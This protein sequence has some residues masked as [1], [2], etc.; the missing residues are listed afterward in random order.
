MKQSQ[1]FTKTRKEAPA[2]EVSK[3]AELL[4]RGGFINK[5]MAGV[6]SY[7]PLGL[8]VMNKISN[9]IREE[10]DAIGGQ[11]VKMTVL[12]DADVWQKS[13][14]WSDEVVDNWFKTKLKNDTEIGL[15]F[16]HEEPLTALLK[17]H[18]QSYKDLPVYPYQIQAKFR[19]ETR[20]KS[21]V[22]RG[23]E[24]LM[25]DMYSFSRNEAEH[26]A[27]YEKVQHAYKKIY[28]R[29]GVG[30]LTYMTFA[31][32]GTF[33][34]YSHEFQTITGAGEDLIYVDEETGIAVNQEV[35]NEEVLTS[36]G[37]SREKLVEQKAVEVGN[38][39]TLG[40]KYSEPI[41][42]T[43]KDEEGKEQ[44]VFMGS[45]GLGPSRLMGTIVE[46][47][48]DDKGII[49]PKEVAPFHVHVVSLGEHDKAN[50]LYEKLKAEN[51]EVLFDDR[52]MTAGEKFADSDLLGIPVRV[53]I[54]KRSI[55][56]G[57]YEI[58][59][60]TEEKGRMLGM[61]ELVKELKDYVFQTV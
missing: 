30:H 33:S 10:M 46:V 40:D 54:S 36:L 32:G 8:R 5:E 43:F 35:L 58:K 19:N 55:E 34:K 26:M 29:L 56:E 25:K 51:I 39:F 44:K 16:T 37:L 28:N 20:A 27:F 15:G 61:E 57:G 47:L 24:F 52:D 53:V 18:V 6:Y 59:R 31:S 17:N 3:N 21:G 7:L 41:N 4:I 1:L 22:M 60:R 2:D 45:Y 13:G 12:Q 14:R 38:I 9:I 42:L 48:S 50:E 23:R 49:W 11:E